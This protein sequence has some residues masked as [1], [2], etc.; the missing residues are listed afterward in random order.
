[1]HIADLGK[2]QNVLMRL[3]SFSWQLFDGLKVTADNVMDCYRSYSPKPP[4][5]GSVSPLAL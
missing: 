3:A 1:M 2:P 5:S 4:L